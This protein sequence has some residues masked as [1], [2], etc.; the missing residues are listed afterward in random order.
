MPQRDR[1]LK[2][3]LTQQELDKLEAYAESQGWNK[4]QALR[5][6]IKQLPCCSDSRPN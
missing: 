6:W 1:W 4:S 2:V 3:L 5:E